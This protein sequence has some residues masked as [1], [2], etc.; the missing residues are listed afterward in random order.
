MSYRLTAAAI[1][2]AVGIAEEDFIDEFGGSS[3]IAAHC[4]SDFSRAA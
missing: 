4:K 2:Q 3:T 1:A